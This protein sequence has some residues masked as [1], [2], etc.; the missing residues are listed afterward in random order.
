MAG[1]NM[2]ET[3]IMGLL[4]LGAWVLLGLVCALILVKWLCR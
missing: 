1:M 3:I 4:E 2:Q